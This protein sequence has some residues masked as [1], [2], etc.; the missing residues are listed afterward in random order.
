MT[1]GLGTMALGTGPLG[2]G[3]PTE[4]TAPPEAQKLLSTWVSPALRD[5]EIDTATRQLGEVPATRGR[6][7]YILT[8]ELGASPLLPDD[9]I[10][11]PV[12]VTEDFD[13]RVDAAARKA[14]RQLVVVERII[15]VDAVVVELSG[16]RTQYLLRYTDLDTG[17][18]QELRF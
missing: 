11:Y 8:Q 5:Y 1:T 4:A 7:I 18:A 2:F 10:A 12:L 16:P 17:L 15:T 6:I 13:K 9:G 3:D 14:L